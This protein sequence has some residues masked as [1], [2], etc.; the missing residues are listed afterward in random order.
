MNDINRTYQAQG[1]LWRWKLGEHPIFD[2]GYACTPKLTDKLGAWIELYQH[3]TQIN[4]API[5]QPMM[6]IGG[7]QGGFGGQQ[8]YGGGQQM[9]GGGHQMY[10]GGHQMI[11]GPTPMIG[12]GHY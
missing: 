10:G 9:Y 1:K 3:S 5:F 2:S 8:M 7:G 12:G 11:G 6:M 4:E